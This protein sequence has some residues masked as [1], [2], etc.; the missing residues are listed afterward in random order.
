MLGK[1]SLLLNCGDRPRSQSVAEE[2]GFLGDRVELGPGDRPPT[3]LV[4]DNPFA[5]VV[6]AGTVAGEQSR[7]G[8][9]ENDAEDDEKRPDAQPALRQNRLTATPAATDSIPAERETQCRPQQREAERY[10]GSARD[11]QAEND[12]VGDAGGREPSASESDGNRLM[13]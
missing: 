7:H 13:P 2:R 10:R 6:G 12:R 3:R 1:E 8:K 9:C 11:G 5:L 4:V